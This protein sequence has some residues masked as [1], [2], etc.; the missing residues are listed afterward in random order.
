MAD[1]LKQQAEN[2]DKI[3]VN[4]NNV[5]DSLRDIND[6][7]AQTE[8]EFLSISSAIGQIAGK[9]KEFRSQIADAGR[10]TKSLIKS[11]KILAG[12]TADD[13]KDKNKASKLQKEAQNLVTKRTAIEAKI[14]AL[15]A[16]AVV[17]SAQ[18]REN[19]EKTAEALTN[20][21]ISSQA[22][23]DNFESLGGVV[24]ELNSNTAFFDNLESTLQTIPGL[25]PLIA[26]PFADASKAVRDARVE[27]K[28]LGSSL[29]AGGNEIAKS[30]GPAFFLGSLFK[31][32]QETINLA[33]NLGISA[34]EGRDIRN[35]F[36]QIA[37]DSGKAF[38]NAE[39]L[40]NAQLELGEALGAQVGFTDEQI[41]A[42]TTLTKKI[43]LGAD[44][45]AELNRQS[46]LTGKSTDDI[47]A[48]ILDSVVALEKETGI[49]LNGRKVLAEVAKA[50]GQ[51]GAQYGF[52]TK[53]LAEAVVQSQKLGLSLK[54]AADISRNLL[55]F[56]SSIANELEAE[57]LTGRDLNLERAR[58]LA[59]QGK[60]AEATAEIVNQLGSS[61][62]FANM[63]VIAQESLAKAAGMSADQLADTLRTQETLSALGATSIE[64]L[65]EQGRLDEL[66]DTKNGE[67]LL[68]QFQQQSAADKFQDT[69]LKIQSAIGAVGETLMPVLDIFGKI[70]ESTAAVYTTLTLIG[71]V[72]VANTVK[73]LAGIS[74]EIG[75]TRLLTRQKQKEAKTDI[76]KSGSRIAGAF[77]SNPILAVVGIALAGA[78]IGAMIAKLAQGDD[79]LSPGKGKSGYGDR[80][81]FGPE[82]AISLNNKD[83]VIAGT[84][85]FPKGNDVMSG[86]AGTLAMTPPDNSV[87]KRTNALLEALVNKPAPKVEMD[88]IEIG[89]IAGISAFSIQ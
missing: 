86:P 28:G 66:R 57:L 12:V 88:S 15:R 74:A 62:E 14:K 25:G 71:I 81:L 54:E 29:V 64:Q 75:L 7:G 72:T 18:E 42:Q 58:S 23:L 19:L 37:I 73:T 43:G 46:I 8:Q 5:K 16:Q 36:T 11:S 27:G 68:K 24:D 35:N 61:A 10:D 32:N 51:L 83:T 38:L 31:A 50:T 48:G 47:T 34:E 87:G 76:V 45:A 89:T 79:I 52:N 65:A 78:F 70:A 17:A 22:V 53:A 85:L 60:S 20:G 26:K 3:K 67:L 56:E 9:S 6:L 39:R 82:G 1:N 41:V 4:L 80:V 77:A 33:K 59:L 49:R 69:V 40:V 13:L 2:S 30:F 63:N 21:L 44:E 84:N 55:E